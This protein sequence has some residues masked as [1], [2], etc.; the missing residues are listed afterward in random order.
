MP[1]IDLSL[2]IGGVAL[3]VFAQ[4]VL[5]ALHKIGVGAMWDTP[6]TFIVAI[7]FAVIVLA[8]NFYPQYSAPLVGAVTFIYTV[9]TTLQ[10]LLPD[11]ATAIKTLAR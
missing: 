8:M 6:V 1:P 10:K 3:P 7:I 5:W 4:V 9:L 11:T 2:V